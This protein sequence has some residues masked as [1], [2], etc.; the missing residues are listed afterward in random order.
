MRAKHETRDEPSDC[1]ALGTCTSPR[2]QGSSSALLVR[3]ERGGLWQD[4]GRWAQDRPFLRKAM[5]PRSDRIPLSAILL[6]GSSCGKAKWLSLAPVHVYFAGCV[7]TRDG[8][9]GWD[10]HSAC[11]ASMK[12]IIAGV[13]WCLT[14]LGPLP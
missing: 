2:G 5:P 8:C 11:R 9:K 3:P 7:L 6:H 1:R 4:G 13:P 12:E 14:E 10:M